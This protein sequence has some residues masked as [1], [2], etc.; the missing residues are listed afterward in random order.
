M[1]TV[2]TEHIAQHRTAATSRLEGARARLLEAARASYLFDLP[3]G[4]DGSDE[5]G[6]ILE[7]K[8]QDLDRVYREL[9]EDDGALAF[10][11]LHG[12]DGGGPA[13]SRG[14]TLAADLP[15][16]H[17][18]RSLA[19][20][21][22]ASEE[23]SG[24][25][26]RHQLALALGS[27]QWAEAA[28]S[29]Q[30]ARRSPLILLPVRLEA[31]DEPEARS[32]FY[33][34][35][36][37]PP[38]VRNELLAYVLRREHWVELPHLHPSPGP[39]HVTAYLEQVR[40]ATASQE[41]WSVESDTAV[42]ACFDREAFLHLVDLDPASWRHGS[43]PSDH[44]VVKDLLGGLFLTSPAQDLD[45]LE[46]EDSPFEPSSFEGFAGPGVADHL[47]GGQTHGHVLDADGHQALGIEEV[48]QGLHLIISGPPGS[49]RTQTVANIVAGAVREGRRV[50]VVSGRA[51][52]LDDLDDRLGSA[53]LASIALPLYGG[54]ANT[55]A[56]L[57]AVSDTLAQ[58][59]PQAAPP[60]ETVPRLRAAQERLNA[61]AQQMHY[62]HSFAGISAYE[63]AGWMARLLARGREPL[64][65]T[66]EPAREWDQA[67]LSNATDHLARLAKHV[68]TMGSPRVHPWRGVG[69]AGPQAPDQA[70]DGPAPE[71]VGGRVAVFHEQLSDWERRVRRLAARLCVRA[72]GIGDVSHM[73]TMAGGIL[74]APD[75]D[76][77]AIRSPVWR[78]RQGEI[79][80]LVRNG[81]RLEDARDHVDPLLISAAWKEDLSEVRQVIKAR[82]DSVLRWTSATYRQAQAR[83]KGLAQNEPPIIDDRTS[84]PTR[85]PG[86]RPGGASAG[87]E[88]GSTG[89]G[90]L[91]TTLARCGFGVGTPHFHHPLDVGRRIPPVG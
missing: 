50:L 83:L 77:K 1:D 39:A 8:R 9:V 10:R 29:G 23:R 60:G 11:P 70:S 84:S 19:S 14:V 87:R 33:L 51:G 80:A 88:S 18:S 90:S 43:P 22:A 42:L 82:G 31:S 21:A 48:R 15:R 81:Q 3:T 59:G 20:L 73:V 58:P 7:L 30:I 13:P 16:P 78:R 24:S 2:S 64:D 4:P 12:G 54:R 6:P 63:I 26:G 67:F 89:A 32:A 46:L 38:R 66:L 5:R 68:D 40:T 44:H 35:R 41:H 25:T 45:P 75:V 71:E 49:G 37:G 56:V 76:R 27:L 74:K 36:A 86:P 52:D 62:P 57:E 72:R 61:H 55:S 34:R 79:E 53:G 69:N 17:L 65:V 91:R 47:L 28:G 85:C